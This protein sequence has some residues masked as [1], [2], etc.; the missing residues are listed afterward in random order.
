MSAELHRA[1]RAQVDR[2][3]AELD[4]AHRILSDALA[5][6]HASDDENAC[7]AYFALLERVC[8]ICDATRFLASDLKQ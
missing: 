6:A 4:A 1:L 8:C 2:I 5:G 7:D 3:L